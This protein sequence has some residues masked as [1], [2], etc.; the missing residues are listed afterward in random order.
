MA[1]KRQPFV[2]P[3]W[4]GPV[5]RYQEHL[6]HEAGCASE[7]QNAYALSRM[8]HRSGMAEIHALVKAGFH[9]LVISGPAYCRSTDALIGTTHVVMS[10]HLIRAVAEYHCRKAAGRY[11]DDECTYAVYPLAAVEP[12]A[13]A[14]QVAVDAE[15]LPF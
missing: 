7:M 10:H 11:P 9:V 13:A 8:R 12:A 3:D 5:D 2:L 6:D 4:A 1:R 15:D 14:A